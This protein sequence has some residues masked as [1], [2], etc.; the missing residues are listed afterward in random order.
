MSAESATYQTSRSCCPSSRSARAP[1]SLLEHA[2]V[3]ERRRVPSSATARRVVR[4][5]RC[6]PDPKHPGAVEPAAVI[7]AYDE[8]ARQRFVAVGAA[9]GRP[10]SEASSI[11]NWPPTTA[12]RPRRR[13]SRRPP[14]A[15]SCSRLR[16][17]RPSSLGVG[18]HHR[19]PGVDLLR[20]AAPP[21]RGRSDVDAVA[22]EHPRHGLARRRAR[23][24]AGR[25][26]P[27]RSRVVAGEDRDDHEG[28]QHR[29]SRSGAR[30]PRGRSAAAAP[31]ATR[32][33]SRHHDRRAARAPDPSGLRAASSASSVDDLAGAASSAGRSPYLVSSKTGAIVSRRR[34][35]PGNSSAARRPIS[36][37]VTPDCS[38]IRPR[39]T[40]PAAS[41]RTD[42]TPPRPTAPARARRSRDGDARR[43]VCGASEKTAAPAS[44]GVGLARSRDERQRDPDHQQGEQD[45]RGRGPAE[46][47]RLVAVASGRCPPAR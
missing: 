32:P 28:R 12:R 3:G 30:T 15:W 11:P 24:C 43:R 9:A 7:G 20:R 34:R 5:P 2:L 1:L 33:S 13:R 45:Q 47:D 4:A 37:T 19:G 21:A 44:A 8:P 38:G 10:A 17:L 18:H 46:A 26:G 40:S 25:A 29:Q 23:G 22:V 14:R 6:R 31:V 35:W 39:S 36:W 41:A 42:S 16:V 27:R